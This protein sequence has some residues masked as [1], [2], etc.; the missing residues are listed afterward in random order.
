MSK[1]RV[2]SSKPQLRLECEATRPER[3]RTARSSRQLRRFHHV[4]NSDGV[5]GTHSQTSARPTVAQR[6]LLAKPQKSDRGRHRYRSHGVAPGRGGTPYLADR[7]VIIGIL[8]NGGGSNPSLSASPRSRPKAELDQAF[9]GHDFRAP[10]LN[11]MPSSSRDRRSLSEN[12]APLLRSRA[13][14]RWRPRP[15]NR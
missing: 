14:P 7:I 3:N 15:P 11:L 6:H 2:L 13:R 8:D 5:F 9:C 12:D 10:S 1:H 4:I